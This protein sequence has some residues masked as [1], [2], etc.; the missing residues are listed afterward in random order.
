VNAN[1]TGDAVNSTE[2][3]PKDL[4][5]KLSSLSG[6]VASILIPI[7]LALIGNAYSSALK[8]SE[9]RVKYTELAVGILKERPTQA[10]QSIR[11][12]AISVLNKH[13]GV[14]IDEKTRAEL[15]KNSIV[16][17]V[18]DFVALEYVPYQ[19]KQISAF[20]VSDPQWKRAL[21]SGDQESIRQMLEIMMIEV[22]NDAFAYRR[23]LVAPIEQSKPED[24]KK[25]E[26]AKD[27]L[28][29]VKQRKRLPAG[30]LTP[31]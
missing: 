10:N 31:Q 8:E 30:D 6:L 21:A 26:A 18:E 19:A 25:L 2:A 24:S 1:H 14:E 28:D 11:S 5:D 9:N 17:R 16:S 20:L 15:L 27:L 12:W 13:S 23:K 29:Q 22:V 7:A 3:R 4:W